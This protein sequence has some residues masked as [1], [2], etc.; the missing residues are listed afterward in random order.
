MSRAWATTSSSYSHGTYDT[1]QRKIYFVKVH[2][3]ACLDLHGRHEDVDLQPP[4]VQ[5]TGR[6]AFIAVTSDH[7]RQHEGV[8][9]HSRKMYIIAKDT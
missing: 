7:V 8:A 6:V 5:L 1:C 9:W 2:S 3:S 4:D